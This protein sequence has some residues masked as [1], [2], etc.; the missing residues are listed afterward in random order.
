MMMPRVGDEIV[1]QPYGKGV[2]RRLIGEA[3]IEVA[4]AR[5]IRK[6]DGKMSN[7]VVCE[8]HPTWF[9]VEVK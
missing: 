3:R 8:L 1:V 7:V 5:I 2:V 9:A 6:Q 4:T